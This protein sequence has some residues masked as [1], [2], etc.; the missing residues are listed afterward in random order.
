MCDFFYAICLLTKS[1]KCGIILP[2]PLLAR[3]PEFLSIGNLY[4]FQT[5]ILFILT[6]AFYPKI[7]YTKDTKRKGKDKMTYDEL[8]E[9]AK[10]HYNRGGDM[11]FE[12]WDEQ[13]Y[14]EYICM[15]GPISEK[16]AL[17]LFETNY[18][19]QQ[20]IEKA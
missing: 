14:N 6:I 1:K 18:Y 4:K 10:K 15:F 7:V 5:K 8:L 17:Q 19:I 3:G 16:Q 12:C 2:G 13:F 11:V 9:L 20:D